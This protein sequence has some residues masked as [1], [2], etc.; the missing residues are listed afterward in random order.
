MR[1]R[2][3]RHHSPPNLAPGQSHPCMEH[4]SLL[5]CLCALS[6][7]EFDV[8]SAGACYAPK[9]NQARWSAAAAREGSTQTQVVGADRTLA[10]QRQVGALLST[11]E[12]DCCGKDDKTEAFKN[13]CPSTISHEPLAWAI[14]EIP[15]RPRCTDFFSTMRA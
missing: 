5:D 7:I 8:V 14:R 4:V 13:V 12:S 11:R 10:Q 6:H 15:L 9:T 1:A 2:R 3:T